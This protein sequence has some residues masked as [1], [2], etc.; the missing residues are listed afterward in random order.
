MLKDLLIATKQ[1]LSTCW[2][3]RTCLRL[4]VLSAATIST[5]FLSCIA[6]HTQAGDDIFVPD[7]LYFYN[8]LLP[9]NHKERAQR[10]NNREIIAMSDDIL[11]LTASYLRDNKINASQRAL[12]YRWLQQYSGDEQ[13]HRNRS[14]SK[15]LLRIGVSR[16]IRKVYN[17]KIGNTQDDDSTSAIDG[18]FGSSWAYKVSASSSK[19]RV[20][21]RYDF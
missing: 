13:Y 19:F 20:S 4:S 21:V 16:Y 7:D 11:F 8:P 6:S 14:L 12:N 1:K 10:S 3:T 15:Q 5:L 2:M 9:S 18:K 17:E